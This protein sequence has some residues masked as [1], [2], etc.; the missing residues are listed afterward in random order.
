MIWRVD[1]KEFMASYVA[2]S[3]GR[4]A[5]RSQAVRQVTTF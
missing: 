3:R 4:F 5:A 1:S 2:K